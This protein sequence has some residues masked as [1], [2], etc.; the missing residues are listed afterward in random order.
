MTKLRDLAPI[1]ANN[2]DGLLVKNRKTGR[3]YKIILVTP[4][5][6]VIAIDSDTGATVLLNADSTHYEPLFDEDD[7]Y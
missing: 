2:V 3:E 4:D 5:G 7:L 6:H 1:D